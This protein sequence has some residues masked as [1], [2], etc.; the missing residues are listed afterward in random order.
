M[1]QPSFRY[2]EISDTLSIVFVPGKV[3]T[4]IE[5]NE[6]LLLR[7]DKEMGQAV[8][9][10]IFEYSIVAQK[11]ETGSRSLPLSG[12]TAL[13]EQTRGLV[14]QI[15]LHPPVSDFLSL[16]TYTPTLAETWPIAALRPMPIAA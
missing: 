8:G 12:L 9:L 11:T 6:Y 13:S 2:D 7:V 1:Q 3:A 5:L 4:G 10:E 15:L 14:V 16:S